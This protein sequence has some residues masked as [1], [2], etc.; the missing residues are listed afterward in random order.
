MQRIHVDDLI[1]HLLETEAGYEVLNLPAVAQSTTTYDLGHG[2]TH[3]RE[4]GDVLHPAHEPEEVLRAIKKSM[5]SMLFSAQYRQ[6]P[7]PAGG[8]II[9]RKM[10]RYYSELE[11]LPDRPDCSQLGHRTEREGSCRLFRAQPGRFVLRA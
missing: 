7:E 5:G 8:K 4:K 3:T 1:G 10:L 11:R 9:K 2:R 6:S